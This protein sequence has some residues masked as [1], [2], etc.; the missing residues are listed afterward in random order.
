ML[1][2]LNFGYCFQV[3]VWTHFKMLMRQFEALLQM[4]HLIGEDRTASTVVQLISNAVMLFFKVVALIVCVSFV[5]QR[6]VLIY[7]GKL[8][9]FLL[10]GDVMFILLSNSNWMM[11][12]FMV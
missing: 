2:P 3:P 8:L 6:L 9:M 4:L 5:K 10:L 1:L 11:C 7:T 12:L